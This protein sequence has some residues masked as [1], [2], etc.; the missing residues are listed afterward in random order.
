MGAAALDLGSDPVALTFYY[1]SID[2]PNRFARA[3]RYRSGWMC[4]VEARRMFSFGLRKQDLLVCIDDN[5]NQVPPYTAKHIF[6]MRTGLPQCPSEVE[7]EDRFSRIED[8][9]LIDFL[10]KTDREVTNLLW[11]ADRKSEAEIERAE[12]EF[13]RGLRDLAQLQRHL[14][15]ERHRNSTTNWQHLKSRAKIERLDALHE[16]LID[17]YGRELAAMRHA[18][19]ENAVAMMAEFDA[20]WQTETTLTLQWR[21][22]G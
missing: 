17:A 7:P 22:V 15:T 2:R 18:H 9:L 10:K 13:Q 14:R 8:E 5:G 6:E 3:L 19:E 20:P 21:V 1:R 16:G 4:V 11:E 12:G